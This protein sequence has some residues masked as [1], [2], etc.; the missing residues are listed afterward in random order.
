MH[1]GLFQKW[2]LQYFQNKNLSLKSKRGKDLV[3]PFF[4]ESAS[5]HFFSS[6]IS[7]ISVADFDASVNFNF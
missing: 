7:D 6:L 2:M 3:F 1:F 5:I 4:I